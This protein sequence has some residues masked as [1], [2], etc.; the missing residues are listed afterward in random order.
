MIGNAQA[1]GEAERLCQPISRGAGVGVHQH[2]DYGAGWYRTVESHMATVA[3]VSSARTTS[4]ATPMMVSHGPGGCGS[5]I[6]VET[7]AHRVLARP[8]GISQG[9]AG[10]DAE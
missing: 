10:I 9:F 8:L 6:R 7:L 3:D 1:H 2:G 5:H 4:P